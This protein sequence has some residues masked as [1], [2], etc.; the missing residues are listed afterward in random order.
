MHKP[1]CFLHIP[2]TAGTTLNNILLQNYEENEVISLYTKKDFAN[3]KE[4]TV[5]YLENIKLIQGHLLLQSYDP[6]QMYSYDVSVFTFLR[7]P[8]ARVKSEY[9][10][11]KQWKFSHMYEIIQNN[12]MSFSDYI[13]SELNKVKYKGKNFMT[14]A[15]S[16]EDMSS[17]EAGQKALS[18][19]K[20]NLEKSFIFFGI[21]EKFDESLVML[22]KVMSLKNIFYERRNVLADTCKETFS[23]RDIEIAAEYNKLDVDLYTFACDLFHDRVDS[24]LVVTPG[25]IQYF[26][27]MNSKF[28]KLCDLINTKSGM[29]QGDI[30][31][32]K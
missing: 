23:A 24:G 4:I 32:P 20:T 25:E 5:D 31:N 19:A 14:R 11:L 13:T 1:F 12:N 15:I 26:K 10:F 21:Q 7:E 2:R 6:P 30:L 18:K 28:Q 16:G 3:Y 9:L 27:T 8:L 17:L 22:S 29:R